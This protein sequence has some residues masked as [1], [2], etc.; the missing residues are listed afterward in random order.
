[1]QLL[2]GVVGRVLAAG[3]LLR[4][5]RVEPRGDEPVGALLALRGASRQEVRVLVLGVV[6]V[7]ADP[8]PLHVMDLGD[9]R[10]LLPQLQIHDLAALLLPSLL[11]PPGHPLPHPLDEVLRVRH[12]AHA[13]A[14][15][16]APD[17]L[18]GGDGTGESHPVVRGLR[19]ALVKI[20]PRHAVPRGRLNE[21]GIASGAGLGRVVAQTALVGVHQHEGDRG[22]RRRHGWT[23]TGM[24]VCRRICS[25]CDKVTLLSRPRVTCAP[26][27]RASH[28]VR[29]TTRATTSP[30]V[31]DSIWV[32]NVTPCS[33]STAS[34]S[35]T[36]WSPA[37]RSI[38][39]WI[40]C[41]VLCA[42]LANRPASSSARRL[43]SRPSYAMAHACIS[44]GR[45]PHT[46]TQRSAILINEATVAPSSP[47]ALVRPRRP[48][49]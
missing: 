49:S 42:T 5:P 16:L 45:E 25:A 6:G 3:A 15:P 13:C 2:V 14:F 4:E 34:A 44:D 21:R 8:A 33:E 9:L 7:P 32:T 41:T 23:T 27:K 39:A 29:S 36:T 47:A 12:V 17:P 37:A 40:R 24:S 18:E 1:M 48:T 20:P 22:E 43:V 31:P 46:M 38:V 35:P 11:L 10:Q 30:G 26:A 28:L 19:G